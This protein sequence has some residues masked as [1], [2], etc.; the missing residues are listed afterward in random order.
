M[1]VCSMRCTDNKFHTYLVLPQAQLSRKPVRATQIFR[2]AAHHGVATGHLHTYIQLK[3]TLKNLSVHVCRVSYPEDEVREVLDHVLPVERAE[4]EDLARAVFLHTIP[5]CS[6]LRICA[7]IR[8]Y[9][10]THSY[11]VPGIIGTVH[12]YIL[13]RYVR[14]IWQE[15]DACENVCTYVGCQCCAPD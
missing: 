14:I 4:V 2:S 9:H 8:I 1:C 13:C 7:I 5:V 12:T 3:Y 10:H 11:N 15:V 6:Q